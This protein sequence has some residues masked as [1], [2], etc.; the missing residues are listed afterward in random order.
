MEQASNGECAEPKH[1]LVVDDDPGIRRVLGDLFVG[2]GYQVSEAADGAGALE[3]LRA[4]HP[5][6]VVLD[7]MMP[8]MN[9]WEFVQRCPRG[10]GCRTLPIVVMTAMY[11]VQTTARRLQAM[12]VRACLAKPFDLEHMLSLVAL[13]ANV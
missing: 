6:V 4:V 1:I 9:G 11:D 7:L 10:A 2:E 8:N 13:V 5:D 12:G 3:C